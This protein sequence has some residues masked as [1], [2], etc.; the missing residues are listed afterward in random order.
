M[1]KTIDPRQFI[2]PEGYPTHVVI[3]EGVTK[4]VSAQT[5]SRDYTVEVVPGKYPIRY[6]DVNYW[7]LRDG[8]RPY[9]AIATVDAIA[10]TRSESSVEWGGVALASH[11]VQGGE[12]RSSFQWYAYEVEGK[13][14]PAYREGVTFVYEA[15]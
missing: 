7:T 9:Y 4:R 14:E 1:S 12:E 5:A 2:A 8:A 3:G 10:P 11:V 15:Q 13:T 6:T